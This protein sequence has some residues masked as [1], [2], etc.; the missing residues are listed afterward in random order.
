[1]PT[2][3]TNNDKF[4]VDG[5]TIRTPF[6]YKPVFATTSTEKSARTQD[7]KMHNTVM[8]TISGYDMTWEVLSWEELA[9]IM[10]A[11]LIYVPLNPFE[12]RTYK[13]EFIFHHPSPLVPYT[14]VDGKFYVA[15]FNMAA[16]DLSAD[17]VG[18]W[19]DLSIN[20]RSIDPISLYGGNS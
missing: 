2:Q 13:N 14:W 19:R 16:Q 10:N 9:T 12:P 3:F 4:Q 20:V 17:G 15:D 6:T 18:K 1:M 11:M 7:L 5:V 8:G